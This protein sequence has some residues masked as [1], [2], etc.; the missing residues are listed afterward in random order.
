M[1]PAVKQSFLAPN[2]GQ[3]LLV[4]LKVDLEARMKLI[5]Y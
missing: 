1:K 4:C 3:F 5:E 2:P